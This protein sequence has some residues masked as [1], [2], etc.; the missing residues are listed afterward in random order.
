MFKTSTALYR[1]LFCD[2]ALPKP[3]WKFFVN[4]FFSVGQFH[5]SKFQLPTSQ[6]PPHHPST[7]QNPTD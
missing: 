4:L 7:V 3:H 1:K 6:I 5:Y 2:I